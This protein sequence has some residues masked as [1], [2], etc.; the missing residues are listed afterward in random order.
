MF[1]QA[2]VAAEARLGAIPYRALPGVVS[3]EAIAEHM[4]LWAGYELRSVLPGASSYDLAG[5]LLHRLF[6]SQLTDH[7]TG[8]PTGDIEAALS[9]RWG[10][11]DDWWREMSA[12]AQVTHGWAVTAIRGSDLRVLRLEAHDEGAVI[13]YEPL[14]VVD[15]YEHAYWMDYGARKADYIATLIRAFD[16]AEITRRF[17]LRACGES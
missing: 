12:A 1:I 6:F 3:P 4:Q 8:G 16:W 2:R 14:I 17:D 11:I 13:G 5:A 10:S 15:C 7:P 9:T